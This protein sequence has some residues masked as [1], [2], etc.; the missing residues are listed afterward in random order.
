MGWPKGK[1]RK[2]KGTGDSSLA[3]LDKPDHVE[4]VRLRVEAVLEGKYKFSVQKEDG[5][6][7]VEIIVDNRVEEICGQ[8]SF[9]EIE[10]MRQAD[11]AGL[12][13]EYF[14]DRL[15]DFMNENEYL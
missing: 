6:E 15:N 1:S 9:I 7:R 2:R 13:D 10:R 3:V 5:R 14:R 11:E 4:W 12:H 8:V